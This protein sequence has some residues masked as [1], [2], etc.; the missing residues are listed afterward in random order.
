VID[1]LKKKQEDKI[2]LVFAPRRARKTKNKQQDKK[3]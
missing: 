3:I 1:G 2:L